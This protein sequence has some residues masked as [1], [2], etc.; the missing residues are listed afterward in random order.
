M[1]RNWR[2]LTVLVALLVGGVTVTAAA[3]GNAALPDKERRCGTVCGDG[4]SGGPTGSSQGGTLTATIPDQQKVVIT[5]R[6][7]S[8]GRPVRAS[9]PRVLPPCYYVRRGSGK[10]MAARVRDPGGGLTGRLD[11]TIHRI[12]TDLPYAAAQKAKSETG[13]FWWEPSCKWFAALV[14][15]TNSA[16]EQALTRYRARWAA[17]HP[18]WLLIAAGDPPPVVQ[19]PSD[20]L[21]MMAEV[22]ARR[23]V[24]MPRLRFDPAEGKPT[25]VGLA[26][27]AWAVPGEWTRVTA[28]A[29]QGSLTA[30]VWADPVAMTFDGLPVGSQT[31][32][33]DGGGT[34]YR[35]PAEPTCF[36]RFAEPSGRQPNRLWWVRIT[37][38][39]RVEAD[40]PLDGEGQIRTQRTVAFRVAEVE[41]VGTRLR[42]A[43]V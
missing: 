2:C 10:D 14:D 28:T 12:F 7:R 25:F 6:G 36:L 8:G 1:L 11:D 22:E 32:T 39:W 34:P 33:C 24:R 16:T 17:E 23:Q 42:T 43:P 26:T 35:G 37:V 18:D 30:H 4:S 5:A 9:S 41:A 27:A 38:I 20:V 19:V 31:G 13:K 3:P 29:S 21:G 15:P 40:V